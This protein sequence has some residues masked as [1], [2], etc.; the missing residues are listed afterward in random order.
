MTEPT[1]VNTIDTRVCIGGPADGMR[2]GV[3]NGIKRVEVEHGSGSKAFYVEEILNGKAMAFTFWR[4][5]PMP[6]DEALMRL[7]KGYKP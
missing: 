6:C 3:L 1:I 2:Y 5:E 7:F 4:W